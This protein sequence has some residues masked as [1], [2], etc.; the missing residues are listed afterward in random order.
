MPTGENHREIYRALRIS[1]DKYTYFLLA[2]TAAAIA[3][4]ITQTED[5]VLAWIH[6]PLGIAVSCWASSF[7]FGIRNLR[8]VSATLYANASIFP[9]QQGLEPEVGQDPS[10]IAAAS[11]GIRKAADFN[12][13]EGNK[14]SRYQ[15]Y[16]LFSGALFFIVWHVLQMWCRTVASGA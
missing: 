2:V 4:S 5:A 16:C 3:F 12:A 6:L 10:R 11:E 14:S 13:E 7:F 1:Q 15:L 9:V 8:Y